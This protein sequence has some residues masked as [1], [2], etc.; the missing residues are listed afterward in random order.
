MSTAPAPAVVVMAKAPRP[1]MVK[2]RLHSLLGPAGCAALQEAL[3]GHTTELTTRRGL[4]TYLAFDPPDQRC[5]LRRLVPPGVRL[6]PQRGSHLGQRLAAAV[7][8]VHAQCPG[9]LVV[10]GTD[11]PT[12]TAGL[13]VDAFTALKKGYDAVVGPALD[14]GYYLIGMR[15]PHTRLFALDADLWSGENV[16]AATLALAERE[17]L[18]VHLLPPLRDLD[19]PEDAAVFLQDPSL[20]PR[21]AALLQP[22]E[23]A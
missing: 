5:C 7:Q 22:V 18:K 12:L 19:T 9:P 20:P 15:R 6:L 17:R 23:S 4:R 3:I 1:G 16:L 11:A 2:T 14:G 10:L 8:D 21:I 13:L